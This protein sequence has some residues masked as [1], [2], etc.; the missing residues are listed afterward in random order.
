MLINQRKTNLNLEQQLKHLQ[1][2]TIHKSN[3]PTLQHQTI[4]KSF[5]IH[6]NQMKD[7]FFNN[8][9]LNPFLNHSISNS[10]S[11]VRFFLLKVN[12]SI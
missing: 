7:S 9:L 1:S 11:L 10:I 8:T 3:S 2:T 6:Q 5:Q 12:L 4:H